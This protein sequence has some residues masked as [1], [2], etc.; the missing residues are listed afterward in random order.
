MEILDDLKANLRQLNASD[1][2]L[3][4]WHF[5]VKENNLLAWLQAQTQF[6]QLYFSDKDDQAET[7]ILGCAWQT[8][9]AEIPLAL[10][11]VTLYGG[12][13]FDPR[14]QWPE[15]GHCRFILPRLKLTRQGKHVVLTCYLCTLSQDLAAEVNDC[16]ALLDK[17]QQKSPQQWQAPGVALRADSPTFEQ[18]Q[19]QVNTVCSSEFQQHTA[20]VVLSRCTELT[21]HQPV[22]PF[23]LLARWQTLNANCFQFLFRWHDG[24]AFIGCTPERLY[25]R[26]GARLTTEALAGTMARGESSQEDET[27]SHDLLHDPK[28]HRENQLVL[29]DI[30][31]HLNSVCLDVGIDKIGVL[32]LNR[33]LH[34][35]QRIHAY[36]KSEVEDQHL[37]NAMH[38]TP[39]VGGT[40]RH[41]ALDFIAEQEPYARGWYAGAIG[42]LSRKQSHFAVA[43]RSAL[44]QG[45]SVKLF[46][47]AGIVKGSEPESE[48]QEL[49]NKIATVYSLLEPTWR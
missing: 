5:P 29:D 14:S 33:I 17:L 37:L 13:G 24:P 48:W 34:L 7:A 40:P 26:S 12:Q 16:L 18:W 44:V 25:L 3:I 15:F 35:K 42:M 49:N 27:I 30:L 1:E 45:N 39:A 2:A 21:C 10:K 22:D 11:D 19:Q 43:I 20:K 28:I 23:S 36:L 41:A 46:A 31:H 4:S 47:G 9:S 38:P 6:P 8:D 32:K